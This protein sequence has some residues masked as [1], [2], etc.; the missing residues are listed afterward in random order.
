MLVTGLLAGAEAGLNRVLRLDGTA[1]PRLQALA[2]K[3]IA[4]RCQSPELQLFMLPSGAGLQL[5]AHWQAPAD[6]TL[7][8]PA[9][10]LARLALSRDKTT[11]LHHPD[12]SLDGDSAALLQLAGILQDLELDWEYELSR[13]LGPLASTLLA[14]HLRSRVNLAANGAASLRQDLADYLAEESRSLVGQREA[15][16]RFAELD[17]LKLALDRLEVRIERLAS[18][19]KPDA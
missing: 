19:T 9:A 14:G 18:R 10:S 16:V 5:A 6:C 4:V 17:Q 1:L 8:A 2:G 13:W 12:V 15:D 7:S 3:V 11:V